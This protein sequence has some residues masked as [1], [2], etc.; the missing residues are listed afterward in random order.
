MLFILIASTLGFAFLSNP[1]ANQ[2]SNTQ[3]TSSTSTD[4]QQGNQWIVNQNGQQYSF[5]NSK[6]SITEIPIDISPTLYTFTGKPLFIVAESEA[7]SNEIIYNLGRHASRVQKACYGKCDANLPE[8]YCDENLIIWNSSTER[9]FS[10]NESCIFIEG[11]MLAV[12]A[13]LYKALGINI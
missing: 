4:I 12:D 13:F 10:Q 5:L 8:K 6:E 7:I 11:D 1:S 3:D 9:K 2:S